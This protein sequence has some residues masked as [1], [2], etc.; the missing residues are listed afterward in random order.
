MIRGTERT[1][2]LNLENAEA[3]LPELS[4]AAVELIVKDQFR[5]T[6]TV[7]ESSGDATVTIVPADTEGM[8]TM[9]NVYPYNVKVTEDDGTVKVTQ[10]GLFIVLADVTSPSP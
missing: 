2:A 9:R 6:A 10:R 4:G 1:F 5:K 3:D 8:P 7:D